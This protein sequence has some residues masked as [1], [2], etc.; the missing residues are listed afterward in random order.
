MRKKLLSLGILVT[1]VGI[2]VSCGGVKKYHATLYD[3]A[4]KWMTDEYITANMTK[5]SMIPE[6][7]ESP[8]S[9]INTIRTESEFEDAFTTF[10]KKLDF[11]KEMLVLYFFTGDIIIHKITGERIFSYR[12]KKISFVD[13]VLNLT[14]EKKALVKGPTGSPPT[15]E[16]LVVAMDKL[17]YSAI[18]VKKIYK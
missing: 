5:N 12:I 15:Q 13:E 17:D 6:S 4:L 8:G 16:C 1:T 10:P 2:L 18:N 7:R 9:I 14:F 3:T 11:E